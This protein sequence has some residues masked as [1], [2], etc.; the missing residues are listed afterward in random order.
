MCINQCIF[1]CRVCSPYLESLL[2]KG[3]GTELR[4][5]RWIASL[6]TAFKADGTATPTQLQ[7][8]LRCKI[9]G[10]GFPVITLAGGGGFRKFPWLFVSLKLLL[11]KFLFFDVY[12][13]SSVANFHDASVRRLMASAYRVHESSQLWVVEDQW[14]LTFMLFLLIIP[15]SW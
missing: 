1:K 15:W 4:F 2:W 8:Q 5:N 12:R 7:L 9:K 14:I 11:S 3:V 13:F 10:A 6:P